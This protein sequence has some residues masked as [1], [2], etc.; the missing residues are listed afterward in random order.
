MIVADNLLRCAFF[1]IGD[2]RFF[3]EPSWWYGRRSHSHTPHHESLEGLRPSRPPRRN[4]IWISFGKLFG[5]PNV[6][7]LKEQRDIDGLL[8]ALRH[9]DDYVRLAAVHA[10]GA[11]GD[12][13]AVEPICAL[14]FDVT[15][16]MQLAAIHALGVL[17]DPRA[18]R[19]LR[20]ALLDKHL[21]VRLRRYVPWA[22]STIS[23]RSGR[24]A[25][26]RAT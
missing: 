23:G 15:I 1:A 12:P 22:H 19:L 17:G 25:G 11:L 4:R 7:A 13:R 14:M 16:A 20:A 3:N 8:Q 9:D 6:E 10:L 2:L 18:I 21:S 24:F 5:L 26:P